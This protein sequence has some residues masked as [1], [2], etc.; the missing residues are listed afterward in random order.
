[1]VEDHCF[2]LYLAK[3]R[4]NSMGGMFRNDSK[5]P[6]NNRN[7]LTNHSLKRMQC[8]LALSPNVQIGSLFRQLPNN[9]LLITQVNVLCQ[10]LIFNQITNGP[11]I[12]FLT[13]YTPR[14]SS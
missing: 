2:G 12:N 4:P 11:G 8:S 9:R 13:P 6:F 5:S 14:V 10:P 1:M 7:L 3:Y